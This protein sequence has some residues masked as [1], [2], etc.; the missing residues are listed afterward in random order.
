MN[1]LPRGKVT[2]LASNVR[3]AIRLARRIE[4]VLGLEE[5]CAGMAEWLRSQIEAD[6]KKIARLITPAP[7]AR[8]RSQ[9]ISEFQ[10]V[11]VEAIVANG[12]EATPAAV[13]KQVQ[14]I[15]TKNKPDRRKIRAIL[16]KLRREASKR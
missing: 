6:A 9:T 16:A 14:S 10:R 11:M 2:L 4:A 15:D 5:N 3:E 7:T 12:V 13:L 1:E 8:E